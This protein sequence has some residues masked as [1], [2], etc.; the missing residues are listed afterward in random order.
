TVR[1]AAEETER[2]RQEA[3]A[4]AEPVEQRYTAGAVIVS[5]SEEVSP[6]QLAVLRARGLGG[7]EQWRFSLPAFAP[8]LLVSIVVAAYLRAYRRDIWASLRRLVLLSTLFL[9]FA[10]AVEV[11]VLLPLEG[12]TWL[13]LLPAG[14]L[15][16]L[17]TILLDPPIGVLVTIPST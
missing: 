3:A 13:F 14:A 11:L 7:I 8:L 4:R 17:A 10:V 12:S 15:A 16:M 1:V 2:R 5:A 6:A 9:L